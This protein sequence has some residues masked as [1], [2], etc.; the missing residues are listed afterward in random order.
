MAAG[1]I[2]NPKVEAYDNKTVHPLLAEKTAELYN[3]VYEP[4]LTDEEIQSAG[5]A[6]RTPGRRNSRSH[7]VRHAGA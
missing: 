7:R 2:F 5:C 6:G 1:Y 3:Y 4:N